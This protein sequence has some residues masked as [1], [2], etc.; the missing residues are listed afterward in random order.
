MKVLLAVLLAAL[1][2]TAH[3]HKPSDAYLTLARDGGLLTGQLDVAL[4]DLD[5][6]LTLDANGDGDITW[7]ELRARHAD[8][9]AYALERVKVS[10]AGEGCALR[11]VDHLVDT[12]T[13]GAYAVL[14]LAGTCAQAGPT[15]AVDYTLFRDLDPQHRGLLNFVESG[16]SRSV[17]R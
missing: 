2:A 3:A 1:A 7:G 17:S 14:R 16:V 13:D 15:V 5:N 8:I 6:A 4:R 10:S 9:A 11:V 12:H